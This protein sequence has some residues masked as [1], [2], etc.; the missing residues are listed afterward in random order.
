[1]LLCTCLILLP[2]KK[3]ALLTPTDAGDGIYEPFEPELN[4]SKFG[5]K[6][7][8]DDIPLLH[9]KIASVTEEEYTRKQVGT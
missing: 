3:V 6:L 9:E 7:R 1:M 4:Y 2:S 8:E 5:L